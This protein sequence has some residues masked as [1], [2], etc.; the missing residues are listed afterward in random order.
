MRRPSCSAA[1]LAVAVAL[2]ASAPPAAGKPYKSPGYKGTKGF[3]KVTTKPLP[4]SYA[5]HGQVPGPAR[6]R[7]RDRARHL[8]PGRRH[9]RAGHAGHLQPAARDQGLRLEPARRRT[10][11]RRPGAASTPS[12]ATSPGGNH[13]FDGPVPL[14]IG[15]QL[16]VVHG[17]SRTSSTR[18]TGSR[19]DS[20]VFELE[21]RRRRRH[22]DRARARSATTRWPAARSPTGTRPRRRSARSAGRRRAAPRSRAPS[23]GQYT[24]ARR[25]S[26]RVTRP[27]TAASPW[28]ATGPSPRSPTSAAT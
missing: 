17:A 15:N 3:A 11:R 9:R 16:F 10:R 2:L 26:A 12:R 13:D 5:R 1:L 8:H 23:P 21:L 22:A 25:C 7:R 18:R 6:R 24:T 20:N 28:T 19:R 14:A 27:T 4:A